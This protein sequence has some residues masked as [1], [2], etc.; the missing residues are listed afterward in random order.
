MKYLLHE[1]KNSW[2]SIQKMMWKFI[3]FEDQ[4]D[5]YFNIQIKNSSQLIELHFI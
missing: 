3:E 2:W 5:K 1:F 4:T